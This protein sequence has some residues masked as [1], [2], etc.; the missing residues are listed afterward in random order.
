DTEVSGSNCDGKQRKG[1]NRV[2]VLRR[3]SQRWSLLAVNRVDVL[4]CWLCAAR[5]QSNGY[6]LDLLCVGRKQRD[7]G[8]GTGPGAFTGAAFV[9]S[10]IAGANVP[11]HWRGWRPG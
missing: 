7:P 2:D 8:P 6:S 5:K 4:R 11:E 10:E 1:D 3:K 9:G